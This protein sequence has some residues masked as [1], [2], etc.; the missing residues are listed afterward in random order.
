MKLIRMDYEGDSGL[1]TQVRVTSSVTRLSLTVLRQARR[2]GMS[3]NKR[4]TFVTQEEHRKHRVEVP[5]E[6]PFEE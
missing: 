4:Y 1:V 6:S 2:L 5:C 3:P